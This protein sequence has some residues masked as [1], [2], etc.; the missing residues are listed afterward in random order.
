[1]DSTAARV[2][3]IGG[4]RWGRH[5]V[6]VFHALGC[7]AGVVDQDRDTARALGERFAC[8]AFDDLDGLLAATRVT[9]AAIATPAETH[10]HVALRC[11]DRGLDIFVEKPVALCVEDAELIATQA[12]R[13]E[14][15]LMIGHLLLY[16]PAIAALKALIDDGELGD[17]RYVYSNRLN[18]GRVRREENIL[19]SFAPHDVA[20]ILHL[21]GDYPETVS[22][23]GGSWLQPG[24]AD[25][26]V[27]HLAFKDGRR[28]H[29]FVS[30]LHPY[31]EQKLV[32]VGTKKMAVF[33]DLEPREKLVVLD[34]GVDMQADGRPAERQGVRVAVPISPVEPLLLEAEHFIA[35]CR[36][37][38]R[39]LSDGRHGV[40]VLRVLAAAE[41]ALSAARPAPSAPA[42][43]RR[44]RR[45]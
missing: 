12:D 34:A 15:V 44:R 40:D 26:T 31:K 23:V 9:A 21:L 16:H 8:P 20:V 45:T 5:L 41:A 37:R 3:V 32:V 7:L 30:W 6:R 36:E 27:T 4:G 28:A 39:P 25:V 42:P 13:A 43:I 35:C 2:A 10:T 14:R 17:I 24:I 1:L 11:L 19:W 33:D 29:V 38:S 22:A 18:L